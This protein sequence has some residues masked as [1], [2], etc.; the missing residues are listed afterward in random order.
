[1]TQTTCGGDKREV[2]PFEQTLFLGCSITKFS[3]NMGWGADSSSATVSLV[4]DISYAA[5]AREYDA[6]EA[7]IN[8]VNS[9]STRVSNTFNGENNNYDL[10]KTISKSIDGASR[11]VESKV[12]WSTIQGKKTYN[13]RDPGFLAL[14][15][16]AS[17]PAYDIMGVPVYFKFDEGVEFGGYVHSWNA[18]GS[19]GASPLFDVE[20]RSFANLLNNCHLIIDSYTGSIASIIP[21]VNINTIN[22]AVPSLNVDLDYKATVRQ[23]NI[24]NVFNIYGKILKDYDFT[25]GFG[26]DPDG[27]LVKSERGLSA[28]AIYNN[29]ITMLGQPGIQHSAFAPY[30]AIVG[31]TIMDLNGNITSSSAE[32]PTPNLIGASNRLLLTDFGICKNVVAS[33]G[34]FRSLFKLDISEIPA[35]PADL[36]IPGA[37]ISIGAFIDQITKGI[38]LEYYVSFEL[39]PVYTG[40]IKIKTVNRRKQ[41]NR[42]NIKNMVTNLLTNTTNPSQKYAGFK[43]GEEYNDSVVRTMYIGGKQK[44]LYQV[45]STHLALQQTTMVFD[46]YRGTFMP[47]LANSTNS[48]RIPDEKSTRYLQSDSKIEQG[49]AAAVAQ[50]NNEADFATIDRLGEGFD[51]MRGNYKSVES[52]PNTTS[53]N[54][55]PLYLDL[56]CPYFGLNGGDYGE[57]GSG[58]VKS[59]SG[60][61]NVDARK[62]HWDKETHQLKIIFKK[63]DISRL[64]SGSY[65]E[66]GEMIVTENEI[67]AAG[68][69]FESWFVYCFENYWSP[70]IEIFMYTIFRRT[71]SGIPDNY[72]NAIGLISWDTLGKDTRSQ[73]FKMNPSAIRMENTNTYV[74][75][76][77]EDLK[78]V[79]SFFADIYNKYY[80]KQY[81][82]RTP[83]MRYYRSYAGKV[84]A[85]WDVSTDGA[86]E[87]PGNFIDDTMVVGSTLTDLFTDDTGKIQPILGFNASAEKA[88][89]DDWLESNKL[90]GN[91]FATLAKA[92]SKFYSRKEAGKFFYFP[93][94]HNLSPESYAYV[95]YISPKAVRTGLNF[96]PINTIPSLKLK[97][98]HGDDIPPENS[99]KMYVKAQADTRI[100]FI[101]GTPRIILSISDRINIGGGKNECETS[102]AFTM[103][104]DAILANRYNRL[105]K[106]F[107]NRTDTAK[108]CA[109]AWFLGGPA[110]LSIE[111]SPNLS[112]NGSGPN[113]PIAPRA[114]CP[115]FAAVPIQ[116]NLATYG[117]WINHPGL[118]ESDIFESILN[119]SGAVNNLVGGVNV[120]EDAT[121]VPWEYDGMSNLDNI[122]TERIK[123]DV[124][125]QQMLEKGEIN[126]VGF[127]LQNPSNGKSYSIGN[128]INGEKGGSIINNI[129]VD[130][131]E[132]GITS[133]YVM[134]T[135]TRKIGFF[136]KDTADKFSDIA[137]NN[138]QRKKEINNSINSVFNAMKKDFFG[139]NDSSFTNGSTP[140]PLRW[141][142]AGVLA[143]GAYLHLN[144]ESSIVDSIYTSLNYSPDW[145]MKP[146]G[147]TAMTPKDM[148]RQLSDVGIQEVQELP[149]EL[150]SDYDRK[151]IMSL[152]GLL[153]PISFYP[154]MYG[155]T[156]S[157]TKYPRSQCPICLGKGTYT[158]K[159]INTDRLAAGNNFS[160]IK[161]LLQTKSNVECSFCDKDADKDKYIKKSITPK[162]TLPPY[163]IASGNDLKILSSNSITGIMGIS[164]N[165]I[166][167]YSTL[168]PVLLMSGEFSCLQNRQTNDKSAHCIDMVGVGLT[169]PSGKNSLKL[170]YGEK[171]SNNFS[172]YDINYKNYCV[173]QGD[174]PA[175]FTTVTG[176]KNTEAAPAN[177]MRFFGLRGPLMVHGWGYDLEGYPVPNS[178]GEYLLDTS[179][180]VRRDKAGNILYKNQTENADGSWTK[181]YKEH[182]FYKGW[183][184]LPGTW[185]V[186]P[187]DLRWDE[188][189]RVWT[190]GSD[191][192]N[193]WVQIE[194]D[195]LAQQPSRGQII[196][197]LDNNPLPSGLRKLVFVKDN[198][199]IN[200]APR[201]AQIYCKYDSDSGFYEPIYNRPL[202]TSGV[203]RGGTSADIYQVYST[204][205]TSY[206]TTYKNPLGFNV[207]NGENGLFVFIEDSWVLQA[208]RC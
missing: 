130:V 41:P 80:G 25:S 73:G 40:V 197:D 93:L 104:H 32:V 23:G 10:H 18:A 178:S 106:P 99:F 53:P 35:P 29:L 67:R 152:D 167:N 158:Y 96:T 74:K 151:S 72:F 156:Y 113:M 193:V 60:F 150:D 170:S 205:N 118:A 160:D 8:T 172:P 148:P 89:R 140:K 107:L 50:E 54:N 55:H 98:A 90:S 62:V 9:P 120:Q 57:T 173:A 66:T 126:V 143:G 175:S 97:T 11:L 91:M 145:Y 138:F 204:N 5:G 134:R 188:N 199:G 161:N 184:Q 132:N 63:S 59:D 203:V 37:S 171:I 154:T 51:I 200:P 122:I 187:I 127:L 87:E 13:G 24:P 135:Y 68:A 4:Q 159:Y 12:L 129:S 48:V 181:P 61:T 77:Y 3:M 46:P 92:Y 76:F 191:Y 133:N 94:E 33:D 70:D 137:K 101:G 166:I 163:I 112:I 95:R 22:I 103:M 198:L 116:F 157:I 15:R 44:R 110:Q 124:N 164:G 28:Y 31:R 79:H 43:Y 39:D 128:I 208:Y 111:S 146:Y 196:S 162:E 20:I 182:T 64:V 123:D 139:S 144:K 1:M 71:Y 141:S 69:G 42:N 201:G 6:L 190:V 176:Y 16:G 114:T 119:K 108:A 121:L 202:V 75:A 153:S 206:R 207:S 117:P 168:N 147:T 52:V 38:G 131:G 27:Y 14:D 81:M 47:V 165:P 19:Q 84:F 185:P 49:T 78:K 21:N 83:D 149:R 195:L 82:I 100:V 174:T 86:W 88:T 177:N 2:G 125:Y 65:I 58:D 179:G 180:G 189:A 56:I 192:K 45:L 142:P 115:A 155:A 194:Q 169:V 17:G 183:G 26:P 85:D 105:F 34:I 136:N 109:L 102:L 30:G 7:R 186:G 36:Y